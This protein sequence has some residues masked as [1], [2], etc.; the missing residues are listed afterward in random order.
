MSTGGSGPEA[1]GASVPGGGSSGGGTG[2]ANTTCTGELCIC[3]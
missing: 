2:T 3:E 1:G